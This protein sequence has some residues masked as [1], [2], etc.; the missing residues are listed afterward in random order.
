ME[1]KTS[2]AIALF[3]PNPKMELVYYEAIANAIDAGASEITVESRIDP[4]AGAS[5]FE[6]IISDNGIGFNNK[7]F[8]KFTKLLDVDQPDHKGVGRLVYLNYFDKVKITSIFGNQKRFFEFNHA[9]CG[10]FILETLNTPLP[11]TKLHF[12]HFNQKKIHT[13]QALTTKT[14]KNNVI[15]HFFPYFLKK[16]R[17]REYLNIRFILRTFDTGIFVSQEEESFNVQDLEDLTTKSFIA[18]A[19][20]EPHLFEIMYHVKKTPGPTTVVTSICTDGRTI[21]LKLLHRKQMPA[22]YEVVFIAFSDFFTGKSD[23]SRQHLNLDEKTLSALRS[24]LTEHLSQ[25]LEAAI[26][27]ISRRNR[28]VLDEVTQRY[29]H[30]QGYFS[31]HSAGL[32]DRQ[33]VLEQAQQQF[34]ADQRCV[35]EAETLDQAT[36]EKSLE[37]SSRVLMEYILYR[38][39]IIKKLAEI[40]DHHA[41]AEIHQTIVPMKRCFHGDTLNE[42]IFFNNAWLLDDKFMHFRTMLSDCDLKH[43]ARELALDDEV[44]DQGARPDLTI[45]FSNDPHAAHKVDAVIV[46]LKKTGLPLLQRDAVVSQLRLRARRLARLYPDKIQRIWFYGIVDFNPEFRISLLEDNFIEL[47]STGNLFYKEVA[48]IPDNHRESERIPFGMFLLD[49]QAFIND[50]AARNKTFLEILKAGF[51]GNASPELCDKTRH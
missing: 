23:S 3:S 12:K 40:D 34:F 27:E 37:V 17:K 9:F 45:I 29:P 5:A 46:E 30:L 33:Q 51:Q 7:N 8:Q 15:R 39:L 10:D 32:I 6:I 50:A 38:N 42:Q 11:E 43:L 36:Y 13:Y 31:H 21:P 1:I 16:K 4:R 49:Y 28:R 26:P 24:M 18:V 44:F 19:E 2:K 47:Y 25:V 41:E 14:L 20:G 48:I 35:L 22:G